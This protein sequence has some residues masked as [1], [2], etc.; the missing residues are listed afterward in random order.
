MAS[1]L[2]ADGGLEFFEEPH[3]VAGDRVGEQHVTHTAAFQTREI[4][5]NLRW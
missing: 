2:D 1:G 4:L 3:Q 5:G